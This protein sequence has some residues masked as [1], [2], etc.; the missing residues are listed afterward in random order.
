MT[1]EA[2]N[3]SLHWSFEALQHDPEYGNCE[4]RDREKFL[5][6]EKPDDKGDNP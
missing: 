1:F 6:E 3:T 4:A 5:L 2:L